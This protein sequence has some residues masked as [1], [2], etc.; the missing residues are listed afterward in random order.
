[1]NPS[2]GSNQNS[3]K[4]DFLGEYH[5][6]PHKILGFLRPQPSRGRWGW[7]NVVVVAILIIAIGISYFLTNQEI[8]NTNQAIKDVNSSIQPLQTQIRDLKKQNQILSDELAQIKKMVMAQNVSLVANVIKLDYPS[9][10]HLED[11]KIQIKI[12]LQDPNGQPLPNAQLRAKNNTE[13]IGKVLEEIVTTN[14]D[15]QAVVDVE[16]TSIGDLKIAIEWDKLSKQAE[17]EVVSQA[18]DLAL[19]WKSGSIPQLSTIGDNNL[20]RDKLYTVAAGTKLYLKPD[21]LEEVSLTREIKVLKLSVDETS[22]IATIIIDA[23]VVTSQVDVPFTTRGEGN[24]T[25][26]SKI[27]DVASPENAI[28]SLLGTMQSMVFLEDKETVNGKDYYL[29]RFCAYMTASD[30]E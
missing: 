21:N 5:K 29:I 20:Y 12:T 2:N 13:T 1:M 14:Q 25:K 11:K 30:L 9:Q 28:F 26:T 6:S 27:R 8:K 4:L 22:G 24:V 10:A 18:T 17:I 19:D 7:G 3:S 23:Y 16:L 15:G